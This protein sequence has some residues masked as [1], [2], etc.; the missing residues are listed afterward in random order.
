MH[1]YGLG[2]P[3]DWFLAKRYYDYAMSAD[4]DNW[5]PVT[6]AL[7]SVRLK[8]AVAA[9]MQVNQASC[10]FLRDSFYFLHPVT[11]WL[12]MTQVLQCNGVQEKSAAGEAA[13]ASMPVENEEATSADPLQSASPISERSVRMSAAIDAA[14]RRKQSQRGAVSTAAKVRTYFLKTLQSGLHHMGEL[15]RDVKGF[16]V[17]TWSGLEQED[18]LIVQIMALF[19]LIALLQHLRRLHNAMQ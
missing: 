7:E 15:K 10:E 1:E 5:V 18:R 9:W 13:A 8:T 4:A 12:G 19:G 16:V 11:N 3:V 6:V 2:L 17:S 14:N